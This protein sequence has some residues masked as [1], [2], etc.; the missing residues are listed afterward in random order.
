MRPPNKYGL[1]YSSSTNALHEVG[2]L[3]QKLGGGEF[4]LGLS[5]G[6]LLVLIV[7]Q[8]ASGHTGL[9]A[10]EATSLGGVKVNSAVLSELS[11]DLS[12]LS[13]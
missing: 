7:P 12:F 8:D 9:G 1:K 6:V 11:H 3:L 13:E 4:A 10:H 2:S 5:V